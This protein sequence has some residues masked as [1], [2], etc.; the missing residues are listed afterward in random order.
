MTGAGPAGLRARVAAT[1]AP[2]TDDALTVGGFDVVRA[3]QCPSAR[4]DGAY[5][6]SA[7]TA[8]RRIA[9]QAWAALRTA[10]RAVT[11]LEAVRETLEDPPD[12]LADWIAG[13]DDGGRAAVTREALVLLHGLHTQLRLPPEAS[14]GHQPLNWRAGTVNL[15]ARIDAMARPRTPGR[16]DQV[17]LLTSVHPWHDTTAEVLARHT[18]LVYGLMFREPPRAV[19]LRCVATGT[20]TTVDIDDR[21]VDAAITAA[22]TA[23]AALLGTVD[24]RTPGAVCV[25]C[26]VR[27]DCAEAQ[28]HHERHGSRIG[29][30]PLRAQHPT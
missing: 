1:L 5:R 19:R 8:R 17:L 18:A 15:T 12:T 27:P 2:L 4:D 13:L 20:A 26:A 30:L 9:L 14:V 28:A 22:G 6:D 7:L 10:P 3:L 11:P 23:V 29:G 21:A 24:T 16:T 25:R